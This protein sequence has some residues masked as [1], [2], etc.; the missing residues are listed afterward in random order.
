MSRH[1]QDVTGE[2]L[3]RLEW[4]DSKR[5]ATPQTKARAVTRRAALAGGAGTLAGFMLAPATQAFAASGASSIFGVSKKYHFVFVNH[6]TTNPFFTPTQYGAADACSLLGCSYQWTGSQTSNV[7]EMT[8]AMNSAMTAGTDG[9]AIALVDLT[10]F[11]APTSQAL[12][13]GI[14]VVAYN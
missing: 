9:I 2:I 13:S 12:S 14:P 4:S 1:E 6:V 7:S 10:A 5:E 8:N 3:E 11:N